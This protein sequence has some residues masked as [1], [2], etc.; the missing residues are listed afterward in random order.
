[1][2]KHFDCS[3]ANALPHID[4]KYFLLFQLITQLCFKWLLKKLSGVGM[5]AG[6]E[7]KK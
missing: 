4:F 3:V 7:A 1:M 5:G 6:L 2:Q